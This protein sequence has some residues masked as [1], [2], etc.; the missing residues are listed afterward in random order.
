MKEIAA[1]VDALVAAGRPSPRID[2]LPY[3]SIPCQRTLTRHPLSAFADQ[4]SPVSVR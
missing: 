1:H 4:A 3:L 2:R